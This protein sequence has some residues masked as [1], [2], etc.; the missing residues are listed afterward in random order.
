M[1]FWKR[2]HGFQSFIQTL[3]GS[4]SLQEDKVDMC[5]NINDSST[6]SDPCR[7]LYLQQNIQRAQTC[8]VARYSW[9]EGHCCLATA[10]CSFSFLFYFMHCNLR[11]GRGFPWGFPSFLFYFI[12]SFVFGY[13]TWPRCW[14]PFFIFTIVMFRGGVGVTSHT[15]MI[16]V[17]NVFPCLLVIIQSPI[18]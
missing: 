6:S 3:F 10:F 1:F 18:F 12:V 2:S 15:P 14:D 16:F 7:H 9:S 17:P 11:G 5:G 8:T 13:L 4:Y